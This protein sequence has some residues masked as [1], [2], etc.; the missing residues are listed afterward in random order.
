MYLLAYE[1][2]YAWASRIVYFGDMVDPKPLPPPTHAVGRALTT[3]ST[4]VYHKR[5]F[6]R[7]LTLKA[8]GVSLALYCNNPHIC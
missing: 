7:Q 6:C 5:H 4:T 3:L 2:D 8:N 1:A